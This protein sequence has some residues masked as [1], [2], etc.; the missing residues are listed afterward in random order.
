MRLP[1][2]DLVQPA[3]LD[4]AVGILESEGPDSK[5][6]AGG[7]DL[8]VALKQRIRPPRLLVSLE[9]VTG[10]RHIEFDPDTGLRVGALATLTEIAE[11]PVVREHYPALAQS[12]AAVASPQIRNRGTLGGNL[13]LDKRCWYFNQSYD[14]RSAH[15]FCLRA[16]GESCAVVQGADQCYSIVTADTATALMALEA[17]L[18]VINPAGGRRLPLSE[19]FAGLGDETNVLGQAELLAEVRLPAP[20]P[21]SS[22]VYLRHAARGAI[23]YPIV[24]V[25]VVLQTEANVCRRARVAVGAVTLTPVRATAAEE[26]LAGQEITPD[27]AQQAAKAAMR[28]IKPIPFI[29]RT[30]G[31]KRLVGRGFIEAAIRMAAGLDADD[32]RQPLA[33]GDDTV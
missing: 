7:T 33:Q 26:V 25:A 3:T 28:Q 17:E 12:A 13:C 5:V 1:S 22:G 20:P 4:E 14:W 15:G 18:V 23:D 32:A 11:S 10:H 8:V 24:Q 30:P 16:G 2:F 19:F 21:G 29:I 31:Y 9:G 6:I 27:L